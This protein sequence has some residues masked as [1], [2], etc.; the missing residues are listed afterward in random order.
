MELH[1]ARKRCRTYKEISRTSCQSLYREWVLS[2]MSLFPH[3]PCRRRANNRWACRSL[4]RMATLAR[5]SWQESIFPGSELSL[6]QDA[7]CYAGS[8][9]R[10]FRLS[11]G[12]L[13]SPKRTGR[14]HFSRQL[15][16]VGLMKEPPFVTPNTYVAMPVQAPLDKEIFVHP[17]FCSSSVRLFT[18][19][20]L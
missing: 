15:L 17:G 9:C 3:D 2:D 16:D 8:A 4:M 14:V 6:G 19:C 11:I 20:A 7:T 18:P 5:K 10:C 13:H 1:Y 12:A